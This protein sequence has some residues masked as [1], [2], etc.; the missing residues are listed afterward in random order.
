MLDNQCCAQP[1]LVRRST[2][3]P[4]RA[5][6]HWH[7]NRPPAAPNAPGPCKESLVSHPPDSPLRRRL[8][9]LHLAGTGLAVS[10]AGALAQGQ[11]GPP[12]AEPELPGKNDARPEPRRSGETDADPGD[13]PGLGRGA[14]REAGPTDA[15]P[16]DQLGRGRGGGRQSGPADADPSDPPWQGRGTAPPEIR[17]GSPPK[18][19]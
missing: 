19:R 1:Q 7:L 12:T 10:V 14:G 18:K 15:D 4:N 6:R 13:M 11:K 5:M 2:M 16:G 17:T 3:K 8:L 9:V